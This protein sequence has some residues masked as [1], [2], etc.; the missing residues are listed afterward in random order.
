MQ[1]ASL[2]EHALRIALAALVSLA[3][4]PAAGANDGISLPLDPVAM[5]AALVEPVAVAPVTVDPAA[6]VATVTENLPLADAAPQPQAVPAAAA[7]PTP[8][9]EPQP[10]PLGTPPPP[11]PE[12]PAAVPEADPAP[13]AAAAPA[14]QPQ[15]AAEP[16]YQP[17]PSQY[18]PPEPPS[19]PAEPAP[20]SAP[21]PPDAPGG[22][23]GWTCS[24]GS[25]ADAIPAPG[26]GFPTIWNRNW[27]WNC[28]SSAPLLANIVSETTAQYQ[29]AIPRYHLLSANV[30]LP[31]TP[32]AIVGVDPAP[33]IEAV[34]QLVDPFRPRA[35]PVEAAARPPA[36]DA[37]AR[38]SPDAAPAATTPAAPPRRL[39]ISPSWTP[40]HATPR[41]LQP[42]PQ[43][44]RSRSSHRRLARHPL[45]PLRGP[46]IPASSA[47]AA[48]LGGA[49]GGGSNPS[50]LLAPFALALV[51]SAR[52]VARDAAPPVARERDK[53]RKRPG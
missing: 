20:S 5:T 40:Q 43:V 12:D 17:E 19:L 22:D 45:P 52:R 46:V 24:A 31:D 30:S 4:A 28:E 10:T 34:Q 41:P 29:S 13:V 9:L 36:P 1:R 53:R 51:D 37:G 33:L 7:T 49:D 42:K 11:Q 15:A 23:W 44:H 39:T 50:L 3:I 47:G 2:P 18:Q 6:V 35:D 14:P 25:L 48:P 21:P 38:A 16:Q 8:A 32:D 27:T 26:D